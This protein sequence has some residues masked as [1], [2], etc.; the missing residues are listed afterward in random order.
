MRELH[1]L[2]ACELFNHKSEHFGM[3]TL[4]ETTTR[5]AIIMQVLKTFCVHGL[6]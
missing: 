3:S 5:Q 1:R 2:D 4:L 6:Q